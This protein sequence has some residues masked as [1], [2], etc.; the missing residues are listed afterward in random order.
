MVYASIAVILHDKL[1]VA[2]VTLSIC[3]PHRLIAIGIDN[4]IPIIL[5][6]QH[7]A[8]AALRM[9]IPEC[10]LGEHVVQHLASQCVDSAT[11]FQ[12]I[13]VPNCCHPGTPSCSV[14][15]PKRK[16]D[17]DPHLLHSAIDLVS[18]KVERDESSM[19]E[20]GHR[21]ESSL[22]VVKYH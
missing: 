12:R 3:R 21:A 1:I 17:F 16:L 20:G 13:N 15:S 14:C 4:K 9:R 7:G 6:H 22:A 18:E 11:E 10:G 8:I 19:E 5:H 2:L